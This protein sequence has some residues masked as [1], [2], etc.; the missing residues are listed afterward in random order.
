MRK[1]SVGVA[2][3]YFFVH[4][5]LAP[6]VAAE[7]SF[8]KENG[9]EEMSWKEKEDQKSF[10]CLKQFK[11]KRETPPLGLGPMTGEVSRRERLFN[12]THPP[13]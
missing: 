5:H 13:C 4:S 11:S 8:C 10:H 3:S 7:V 6:V 1:T 2:L 12:A 9:V